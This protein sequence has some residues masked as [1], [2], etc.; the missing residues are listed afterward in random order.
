MAFPAD[1]TIIWRSH[2]ES[3]AQRSAIEQAR[4]EKGTNPTSSS[5]KRNSHGKDEAGT[6]KS[7]AS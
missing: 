5:D 7:R 2:D 6:D 1:T 3:I 4:Q